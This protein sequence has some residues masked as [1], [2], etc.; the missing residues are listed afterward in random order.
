[1]LKLKSLVQSNEKLVN[2]FNEILKMFEITKK[3]YN[4]MITKYQKFYKDKVCEFSEEY[5]K[6]KQLSNMQVKF[7]NSCGQAH[8]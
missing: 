1:M 7:E 4:E 8:Y 6:L 5:I 3:Q 2:E